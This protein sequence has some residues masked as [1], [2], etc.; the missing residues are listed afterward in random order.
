MI[1][2]SWNQGNG[3]SEEDFRKRFCLELAVLPRVMNWGD[4]YSSTKMEAGLELK[5]LVADVL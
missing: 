1:R 2:R 3:S 5:I 4:Y